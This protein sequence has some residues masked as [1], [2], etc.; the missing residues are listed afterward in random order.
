MGNIEK[1]VVI[2]IRGGC[3]VDVLSNVDAMVELIDFDN[4]GCEGEE[5]V[6]A[7]ENYLDEL[8]EVPGYRSIW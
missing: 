8:S 5:A 6:K 2:V 4:I 3:L 7:A 1:K